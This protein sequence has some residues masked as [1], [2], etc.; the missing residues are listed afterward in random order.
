MTS[1]TAAIYAF[2]GLVGGG[3][4]LAWQEPAPENR[5]KIAIYL[6]VSVASGFVG[7]G[8]IFD[9][10]RIFVATFTST[11][12]GNG[13]HE[14]L[15]GTVAGFCGWSFWGS[16]DRMRKKL[17]DRSLDEHFRR[18]NERT[19]PQEPPNTQAIPAQNVPAAGGSPNIE[20]APGGAVL[21]PAEPAS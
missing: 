19:A 7:G 17:R 8:V 10:F 5:R 18:A 4:G 3:I 1:E 9:L 11:P 21:P 15:S 2:T 12:L 14:W 13:V 6:G 20:P 16:A